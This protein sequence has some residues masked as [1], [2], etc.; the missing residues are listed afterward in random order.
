MLVVVDRFSKMSHYIPVSSMTAQATARAFYFN[1]F[2]LH[3]LPNTIV[4]DRGTQFVSHF[5][6][7]LCDI[8]GV[9]A[10][11]STAFH[12]ETDGQT[13]RTNAIIETYWRGFVNYLQDDWVLWTPSAEFSYNNHVSEST[14]MTPFFANTGQ[15]PRMGIEP[16]EVNVTLAE[17]AQAQQTAAPGF[18]RK[19]DRI[20]E[21]L[22]GELAKAQ[23]Y[24]EEYANRHREH[25]PPVTEWETKCLWTPE[26]CSPAART[27]SSTT[28]TRARSR[29]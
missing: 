26:T 2:R 11:L 14:S 20:N 21:Q 22:R 17:S 25:A 16:Y 28:R 13:E 8:L 29:S 23:A 12:P 3:G 19:M 10:T 9:K 27:K 15:H 7:A 4:S 5:W 24:Q 1:V 18:G 6:L